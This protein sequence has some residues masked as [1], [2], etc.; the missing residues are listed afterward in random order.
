MHA[1]FR[2]RADRR[3]LRR[4]AGLLCLVLAASSLV[5]AGITVAAPTGALALGTSRAPGPLLPA[6][7]LGFVVVLAAA[8]RGSRPLPPR[9]RPA[10]RPAPET[11][12]KSA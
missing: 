10:H 8:A 4:V 7:A 1:P 11:F 6:I 3:L 12:R 2:A 9:A 5:A